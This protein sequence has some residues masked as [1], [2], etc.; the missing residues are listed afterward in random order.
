[1]G[2]NLYALERIFKDRCSALDFL[3]L[4]AL[5]VN[6]YRGSGDIGSLIALAWTYICRKRVM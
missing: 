1:L 6:F 4:Y 3:M 2:C 5:T